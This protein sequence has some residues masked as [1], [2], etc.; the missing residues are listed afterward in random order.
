MYSPNR[1]TGFTSVNISRARLHQQAAV[2]ARFCASA[3]Q[4]SAAHNDYKSRWTHRGCAVSRVAPI[5]TSHCA[6]ES[7]LT[8]PIV[9]QR[10]LRSQGGGR[11]EGRELEAGRG[12]RTAGGNRGTERREELNAKMLHNSSLVFP[13]GRIII[14]EKHTTSIQYQPPAH[15]PS[16][17]LEAFFF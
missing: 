4:L 17:N 9:T 5:D 8:R 3:P 1:T 6:D 16:H 10:H 7:G 12:V 15:I 11:T 13:T 14:P 2:S